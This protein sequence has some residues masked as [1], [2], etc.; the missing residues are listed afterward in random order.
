M[1]QKKKLKAE[2]YDN[3]NHLCRRYMDRV[4]RFYLCYDFVPD[5]TALQKAILALY[6]QAPVFHSLFKA[7]PVKPYWL[8]TDFTIDDVLTVKKTDNLQNAAIC[9]LEQPVAIDEPSQMKIAL[10]HD[11]QKCILAFRW[12]HMLMDGGGFK[13][14]TADLCAAYNYFV[15]ASG[16]KPTFR[17][18][19]RRYDAVYAD[20]PQEMKKKAKQQIAGVS[21]REKRTLPF[22]EKDGTEQTHIVYHSVS[23]DVMQKAIAVAKQNGATVNDLMAAAYIAAV[24]A[25]TGQEEKPLN[26]SCAVDLRRYMRNPEKIG[27]T[28]HTTFM[29]CRVPQLGKTPLDTLLSVSESNKKNKAD[30]F[31]GLHG[32]PLLSFAYSSMIY[33]QADAVVKLFYNNA[34]LALSN[35]GAVE[36]YNFTLDGHPVTDALVAGGAKKKPCAAATALTCNGKLTISVCTRGNEK[37]VAMLGKFFAEFEHYLRS[38]APK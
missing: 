3:V 6:E 2:L 10:I 38:I 19:T 20:M 30:P 33:Q 17:N 4:A 9:F 27:Y 7:N 8:V 15:S 21:A 34:N 37:D 22:T 31:L 11:T 35:V 36:Q 23:A 13:Q 16:E 28:N 18:G 12:N 5:V 14:F 32:I 26:L 1:P 25:L 24:Y 29:Y